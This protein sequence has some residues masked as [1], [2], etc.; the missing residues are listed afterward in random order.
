MLAIGI[1]DAI[2]RTM[3]KPA[4]VK[5]PATYDD[6]LQVPDHLIAEIVDGNL[7]ATPRPALPHARASSVLGMELGGPFDRG[8]GG[9]G[10]WWILDEPELH[11]GKDVL[12]P[13]LA[14]WRRER[15]PQIPAEAAL[16]LAPDWVCEIV[17]PATEAL[18]RSK[19][20]Q[21][22]ARERVG[23]AWLINP[24]AETL[25]V[26]RL[27][28]DRWVLAATYAGDEAVRAEPFDAVE[29]DLS[30]LWQRA[31]AP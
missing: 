16:T 20:L 2:L 25:E 18:D 4:A 26:F 13:D 29:L 27:D 24:S 23:H 21:A 7:Y 10:G 1:A 9:P 15:L 11:L 12:V 31:D 17:S 8:R 6:L 5:P 28:G 19:K 3:A 30:A 14:G 22:Y